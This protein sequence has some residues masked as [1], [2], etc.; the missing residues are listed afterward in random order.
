M[1]KQ[2]SKNQIPI[3]QIVLVLFIVGFLCLFL[4]DN[5]LL[6]ENF[7]ENK[8]K[9]LPVSG[10]TKEDCALC[11]LS[12][13]KTGQVTEL[14]SDIAVFDINTFRI[15]PFEF[16]VEEAADGTSSLWKIQEEDLEGSGV[17]DHERAFAAVTIKVGRNKGNIVFDA[18]SAQEK[19]Q[20]AE[21]YCQDCIDS[22][23][24]KVYKTEEVCRIGV[25]E[26]KSKAVR[27]FEKNLRS[28]AL[29]DFYIHVIPYRDDSLYILAD[30]CPII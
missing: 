2:K 11:T 21:L 10:I 14:K 5:G 27:L 8:R 7:S 22:V 1:K 25:I 3:L 15:F 29:K 9:M 16:F 26:M 13:T 17:I 19:Q 18:F 12:E 20:I 30:Y 23:F 24:E 4:S 6:Q 28:F